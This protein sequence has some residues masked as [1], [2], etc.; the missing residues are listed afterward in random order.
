MRNTYSEKGGN[1]VSPTVIDSKLENWLY[2]KIS[3]LVVMTSDR[4][5]YTPGLRTGPIEQRC[6]GERARADML[7]SDIL[8][9]YWGKIGIGGGGCY[10]AT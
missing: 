2:L 6:V 1:R 7:S 9:H 8:C 5:N 3:Y 4:E 10:W